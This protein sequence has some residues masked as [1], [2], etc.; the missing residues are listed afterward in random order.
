MCTAAATCPCECGLAGR[1]DLERF[2]AHRC[3]HRRL[4]SQSTHGRNEDGTGKM[5]MHNAGLRVLSQLAAAPS[6]LTLRSKLDC[7]RHCC[8]EDGRVLNQE[9]LH[10]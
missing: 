3:W 2:R 7:W 1:P 5:Q 9:Q 10:R 4:R 8:W 6:G